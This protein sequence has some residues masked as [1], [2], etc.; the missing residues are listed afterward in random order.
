[1]PQIK[2]HPD[3]IEVANDMCFKLS[4]RQFVATPFRPKHH[5]LHSPRC[6][7]DFKPNGNPDAGFFANSIL[8]S[9]PDLNVRINFLNKFYQ[10]M[11]YSQLP[12]KTRKLVVVGEHDS[13]KSSWVQVLFG[14]TPEK[15]IA[16]ISKEKVFGTSMLDDE[17]HLIFIDEWN[18]DTLSSDQVKILFQG[19]H[20]QAGYFCNFMS[21]F[22]MICIFVFR[23]PVP[24]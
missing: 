19:K 3:L 24:S 12:I 23:S 6:F 9:F 22:E 15:R 7:Q 4:S 16:T 1:M 20:F 13:G 10:C 8:N 5:M 2:F 14:L 11:L 17:T 21:T 18:K